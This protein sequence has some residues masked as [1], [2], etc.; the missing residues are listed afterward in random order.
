MEPASVRLGVVLHELQAVL[1]AEVSDFVRICALSIEVNYQDS[2]CPIRDRSLYQFVVNLVGIYI[3]LH[4]HRLQAVLRDSE[5]GRDVSVRGDYHLVPRLHHAHFDVCT[6]YPYQG[7]QPVA[8]ADGILGAYIRGV[9][10]FEPLVLL[11]LEVPPSVDHSRHGL[12]YLIA[13]Q[14]GHL[15]QIK[16][17]YHF[18]L[19][20]FPLLSL[21]SISSSMPSLVMYPFCLAGFPY[22]TVFAGMSFVTT[23][24]APMNAYSPIVWP[25]T[26]VEFAP[27][28]APFLMIV[29]RKLLG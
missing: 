6:E 27:M 3:R 28:D 29:L 9:V 21:N 26:I 12:V 4:E 15:L 2:P 13:V 20:V 8:A 16:E 19:C 7:V 5:Y 1:P 22:H 10:G 18:S 23:L 25:A 24:P 14:G 17:L 11:A